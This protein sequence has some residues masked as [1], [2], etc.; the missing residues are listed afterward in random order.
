[1][2]GSRIFTRNKAL[3]FV[4]NHVPAAIRYFH[5]R[6]ENV[7]VTCIGK[8]INTYNSSFRLI[9]TTPLHAEEISC[10]ATDPF[11]VHVACGPNIYS[12][13]SS[14]TIKKTFKSP[15]TSNVHLLLAFGAHLISVDEDN[16]LRVWDIRSESVYMEIPFGGSGFKITTILHPPAYLNKILIG[17][18]NGVLQLWNVKKAK[19]VYSFKPFDSKVSESC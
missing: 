17:G 1:M 15:G 2:P 12:W 9:C 16:V 13:R 4:S 18:E 10:I 8:S 19:L 14:R 11:L 6:K 3:G 5:K 7:I